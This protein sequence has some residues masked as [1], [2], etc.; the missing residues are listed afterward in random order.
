MTKE[1]ITQQAGD[2][3]SELHEWAEKRSVKRNAKLFRKYK[4][5]LKRNG[6]LNPKDF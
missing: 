5:F 6:S 4:S 3:D 2:S 1:E